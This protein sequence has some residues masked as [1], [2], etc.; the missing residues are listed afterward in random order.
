MRWAESERVGGGDVGELEGKSESSGDFISDF[1]QYTADESS[2][3]I[4]RRWC[5]IALVAGALERRVF[6]KTGP[7]IT[8]PNLYVLLVAP[9]GTGKFILNK[10]RELWSEAL[11]PGTKTQAFKVAPDSMTKAAL[12]DA[13]GKAKQT[14]ILRNG[15]TLIYHSLLVAA[16]EFSVLLPTYDMEYIGTLNAI[17]NN[18]SMPFQ[19]NRRTGNRETK[20][21][22]PQLNIIGGVQ[23]SFLGNVFPEEV[24]TTGLSRRMIMVYSSEKKIRDPFL[25]SVDQ[26]A[27]KKVLLKRLGEMSNLQ[28]PVLWAPEAEIIMRDWV[29]GGE[30]PVPTHSKLQAYVTNRRMNIMK[31]A[32]ISAVSRGESLLISEIDVVR[33]KRWLFDAEKV[34]PDI[35]RAMMGKSDWQVVEELHYFIMGV[36]GKG[37]HEPVDGGLISQ[38]VGQRVPVDKVERIIQLA[39]RSNVIAET[40][41]GSNRWKPLPKML[42]VPE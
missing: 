38:F 3:E 27:M 42:V 20:I 11:E 10:V 33:A 6:I 8:F 21:E 7:Y 26:E 14:R 23:P 30:D 17:W 18:P 12:V 39:M 1:F 36:W 2:P 41:P 9:P 22:F 16:E 5:G 4:F 35:F 15:S 40:L 13:L 24:W 34:M 29:M 37:R 32:G 28:G 19:E 31:L 25:V